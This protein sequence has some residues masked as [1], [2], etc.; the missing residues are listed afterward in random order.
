MDVA[1]HHIVSIPRA[2]EYWR[3]SKQNDSWVLTVS[4]NHRVR[5]YDHST[6]F[7]GHRIDQLP[8]RISR[9]RI[10]SSTRFIEKDNF[11]SANQ[12]DRN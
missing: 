4:F 9:R 5:G 3:I 8:D 6:F 2:N 11:W 10:E 12:R 7:R 1:T